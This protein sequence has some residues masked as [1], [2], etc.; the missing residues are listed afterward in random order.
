[1]N[2]DFIFQRVRDNTEMRAMVILNH[3]SHFKMVQ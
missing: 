3:K 1:M 2:D